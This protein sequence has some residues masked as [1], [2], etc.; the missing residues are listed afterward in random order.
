MINVSFQGDSNVKIEGWIYTHNATLAD[1]N[2]ITDKKSYLH[3]S[4]RNQNVQE[5]VLLYNKVT[6]CS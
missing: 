6:K 1:K 2:F 3:D 4:N 5:I